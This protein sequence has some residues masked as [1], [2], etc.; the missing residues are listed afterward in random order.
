[1]SSLH[2]V[3]MLAHRLSFLLFN[4]NGAT[5][6]ED[7]IVRHKCRFKHCVNPACLELGTPTDNNMGDKL[8]DGTLGRGESN[9]NAK[10]DEE[11]ARAIKESKGQGTIRE[12][13]QL[14]EVSP[15]IV[16]NIDCCKRWKHL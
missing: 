1:M 6:P 7:K 13:A 10:I 15:Y 4:N 12:R 11:T 16:T 5:L 9:P 2:G 8:R 14:F 3:K